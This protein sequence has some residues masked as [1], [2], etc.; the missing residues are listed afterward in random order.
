M[1]H[2]RGGG[3]CLWGDASAFCGVGPYLSV[4]DLGVGCTCP[5]DSCLLRTARRACARTLM[6]IPVCLLL[7]V[8]TVSV[9]VLVWLG[10]FRFFVWAVCPLLVVISIPLLAF[11][12][13]EVFRLSGCVAWIVSV[14]STVFVLLIIVAWRDLFWIVWL[15][16]CRGCF[17]HGLDSC[18]SLVCV[19]VKH[20]Q[21]FVILLAFRNRSLLG[22]LG[23][24]FS[25]LILSVLAYKVVVGRVFLNEIHQV[26]GRLYIS[27]M[28]HHC[29]MHSFE[30]FM[31]QFNAE[32]IKR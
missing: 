12:W 13:P 31:I 9:L 22:A 26:V 29:R 15:R 10:L 28:I 8:I 18:V 27:F 3:L 4:G 7:F 11:V 30:T 17:V 25:S 21:V 1:G 24:V 6:V 19:C 32:T 2:F 23:F 20:V 16:H 5:W 14:S